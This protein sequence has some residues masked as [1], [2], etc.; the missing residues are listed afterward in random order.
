MVTMV[1]R[2][3]LCH[4]AK[5]CRN[6]S[7]RGRGMAIFLIFQ[8]G[9]CCHRPA[10]VLQ[11]INH[12]GTMA[13]LCRAISSQLRHVSTIEKKLLSSNMSS[14]CPHNMVNFCPLAA[15]IGLPV[16]GTSANFN[17]FRVLA[18]L[19]HG[20]QVVGVEQRAPTIFGRA[21][22]TLGIGPHSSLV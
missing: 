5:F 16:W 10:H 20:S 9:S 13:Q 21:A 7:N 19:L 4:C 2:V 22:I 18:T 6:L 1:K 12:L 14:A 11:W 3:E 15:E 8:D 17:S